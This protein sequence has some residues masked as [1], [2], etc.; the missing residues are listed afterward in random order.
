MKKTG[1]GGTVVAALDPGTT[2]ELT[3]NQDLDAMP[4]ETRTRIEQT[5]STIEG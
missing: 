5:L 2:S 3:A 1:Y 4:G